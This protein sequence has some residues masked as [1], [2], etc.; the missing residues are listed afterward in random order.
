MTQISDHSQFLILK[1]ANI[2][3]HKLA[4][5][6]SDYSR[7]NEGNFISDLN[8]IEF[9]YLDINKNYDQFLKD[10]NLLIEKHVPTKQCRKKESKLK[11]KPWIDYR[12]QKMMKIRDRSLR[13]LKKKRSA[14]NI[15][16]YKKFGN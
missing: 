14:G 10:I 5:F 4:V 2:P 7:Y 12:I 11:G 9:N 8:E 15:A 13:K 6:K 3:Q 1:N 16:L